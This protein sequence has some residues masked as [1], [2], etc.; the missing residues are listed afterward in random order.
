M[1]TITIGNLPVKRQCSLPLG[2]EK[3]NGVLK[4]HSKVCGNSKDCDR[5][6]L[7]GNSVVGVGKPTSS[8]PIRGSV[9]GAGD[10]CSP[11]LRL[12]LLCCKKGFLDSAVCFTRGK[13]KKN[14]RMALLQNCCILLAVLAVVFVQRHHGEY[15]GCF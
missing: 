6:G 1:C 3:K 15:S 13:K 5:L 12:S 11:T 10:H 8:G 7:T 4:T 2:W 9:L 14:E